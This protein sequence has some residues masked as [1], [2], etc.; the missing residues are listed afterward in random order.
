[1]PNKDIGYA[2]REAVMLFIEHG[3]TNIDKTL[4]NSLQA[5]R[6]RALKEKYYSKLPLFLRPTLYF[7][8]TLFA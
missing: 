6:K 4:N 2:K 1:M 5:S 3:F 7:I 8:G